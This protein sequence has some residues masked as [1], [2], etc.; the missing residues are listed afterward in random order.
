MDK[1]T[2]EKILKNTDL[3]NLKKGATFDDI[4][5]LCDYAREVNAKSVCVAPYYVNFASN[6]LSESKVLVCTVIGFPNGYSKSEIKCTETLMAIE[7]G[8]DEIDMVINIAMLKNENYDEI[9]KEISDI[10]EI[11]HKHKNK[12]GKPVI[13]KVIVETC[14][15]TASEICKMCDICIESKADYIKTST[16]FDVLGANHEDIKLMKVCIGERNLKIKAAGGIRDFDKAKLMM[17]NGADRIGAS[18]LK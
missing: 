8:A 1:R 7:D 2:R 18:M 9:K 12:K 10:A 16:G 14:L 6:N 5:T 17:D 11:C 3:T 15:L 4:A 13:L